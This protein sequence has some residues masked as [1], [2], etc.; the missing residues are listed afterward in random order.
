MT[1]EQRLFDPCN[2]RTKEIHSDILARLAS[3]VGDDPARTGAS[4]PFAKRTSER[5]SDATLASIYTKLSKNYRPG[6]AKKAMAQDRP[7]CSGETSN[8]SEFRQS[9]KGLIPRRG[10]KTARFE[11]HI[12]EVPAQPTRGQPLSKSLGF[13]VAASLDAEPA[14]DY[15]CRQD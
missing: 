9:V 3:G 15:R 10:E 2:L 1:G 14:V 8:H 7:T 11:Q 13:E 4:Q 12:V 5:I 6:M